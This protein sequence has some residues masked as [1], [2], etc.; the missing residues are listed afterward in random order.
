M[1]VVSALTDYAGK[2]VLITGGSRGIGHA[3]AL[4]FAEAG[5]NLAIASRKVEACEATV[6]E[7]KALGRDGSAHAA[8][9]GKWADCDR[10][11]DEVLARWGKV[12][13]LVNNAGLSPIAPS[14]LETSE[15]LFDK[16][17]G[18]NLKGPFRLMARLGSHMAA[19]GGGAILNISST[20][21]I[22]PTP[23]T[24]PYAAAKRGL[25]ALTEAFAHEY[26]PTVRV[27]CIMC[28]PF[29]TDISKAWSRSPEWTERT[30]REFAMQRVGDPEEVVGAALYL[31]SPAASYTSGAIIRI[32]GGQP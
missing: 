16:V 29:H 28:G 31:C 2:V 8:H 9:V 10:L 3:M 27:N 1:T 21:A 26:G 20:G 17:L 12:D 23:E 32:D 15:D 7:I 4:G 11:A 14:S 5:A 18:V 25:N 13:V 24:A 22:R 30:K 6:A 19:N